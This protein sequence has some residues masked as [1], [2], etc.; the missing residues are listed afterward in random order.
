MLTYLNKNTPLTCLRGFIKQRSSVACFSSY[1]STLYVDMRSITLDVSLNK[2]LAIVKEGDRE[3]LA[4]A[5]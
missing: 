5:R 3:A 4:D 1:D 2:A